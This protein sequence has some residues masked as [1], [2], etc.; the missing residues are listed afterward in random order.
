MGESASDVT[1]QAA[2]EKSGGV[3]TQATELLRISYRSFRH[4]AKKHG[5]YNSAGL[6]RLGS[7]NFRQNPRK[8][9]P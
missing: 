3:R 2:L 5:L 9:L 1:F 7:A 4:L 6:Q 8:T